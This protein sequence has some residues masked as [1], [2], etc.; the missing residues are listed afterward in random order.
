MVWVTFTADFDF[1]PPEAPLTTIAYL[2]GQTL[3]V[4]RGCADQAV[5]L[6]RAAEIP[7]PS[8]AR[9]RAILQGGGYDA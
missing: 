7:T 4:R 6:E 9:A 8:R 1:S 5:A 2:V 3:P